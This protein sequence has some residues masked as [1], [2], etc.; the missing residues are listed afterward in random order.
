MKKDSTLLEDIERVP[1]S[2]IGADDLIKQPQNFLYE[3][4]MNQMKFYAKKIASG[5]KLSDDFISVMM[6][7]LYYDAITDYKMQLKANKLSI[8]P[9]K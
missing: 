8:E 1:A 4:G 9:V 5:E 2:G 6:I 7:D 3:D